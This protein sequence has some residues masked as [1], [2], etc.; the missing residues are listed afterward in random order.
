VDG[1]R[2][3][4]GFVEEFPGSQHNKKMGLSNNKNYFNLISIIDPL[5]L[6]FRVNLFSFSSGGG[7]TFNWRNGGVGNF[8]IENSGCGRMVSGDCII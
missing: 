6:F 2:V 4:Q 7:G 8:Q 1:F 3:S 5:R